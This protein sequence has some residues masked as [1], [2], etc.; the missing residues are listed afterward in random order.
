MDN[1]ENSL[2]L[3]LLYIVFMILIFPFAVIFEL[4]KY[5]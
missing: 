4:L 5:Q 3:T 2:L 1:R